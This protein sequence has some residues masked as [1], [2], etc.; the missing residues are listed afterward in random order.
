MM[1]LC[2]AN[3]GITLDEAMLAATYNPAVS[4]GLEGQ[5]GTLQV[6]INIA[7]CLLPYGV[8]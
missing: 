4:L 3:G 7:I 6:G 8:V 1:Q 2:M 5:A